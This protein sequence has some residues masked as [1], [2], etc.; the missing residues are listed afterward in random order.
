M[1][2][3]IF[4][5]QPGRYIAI[6]IF[7]PYLIYTG[8]KYNDLFLKILGII[9]LIWEIFW[10]KFYEPKKTNSHFVNFYYNKFIKFILR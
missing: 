3:L 1:D 10:I 9:F 8:F 2:Y 4:T 6:F 5:D 7:S